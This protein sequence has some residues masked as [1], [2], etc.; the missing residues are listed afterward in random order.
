MAEPAAFFVAHG[1]ELEATE[2]T[3]GPWHPDFQ[4]AGPP[5]EP[6]ARALEQLAVSAMS[7]TRINVEIMKPFHIACLAVSTSVRRAGRHV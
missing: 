1:A 4:H 3:R 6:L 5:S 7:G 2:L